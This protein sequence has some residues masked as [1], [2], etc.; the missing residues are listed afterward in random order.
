MLPNSRFLNPRN[1]HSSILSRSDQFQ[2][3]VF[4]QFFKRQLCEYKEKWP[5]Y[6]P[7]LEEFLEYAYHMHLDMTWKLNLFFLKWLIATYPDNTTKE[8]ADYQSL[9]SALNWCHTYHEDIKE[10]GIIIRQSYLSSTTE[11]WIGLKAEKLLDK[12]KAFKANLNDLQDI[13]PISYAKFSTSIETLDI[14]SLKWN[15]IF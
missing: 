10:R 8:F 3:Q 9:R 6:H 7:H 11:V 1:A 12:V 14:T 5:D 15:P 13:A 4:L 2:V